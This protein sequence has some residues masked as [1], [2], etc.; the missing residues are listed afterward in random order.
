M[1]P[2]QL[3]LLP[4]EEF[5]AARD[6]AAK[7]AK[8][9]P[10]VARSL[11]AL[12]RPSVA[13]WLVNRLVAEQP[14]LVDQLLDLGPALAAAQ[15][16]G[17]GDELRALG[18]QRRA[19][20]DAV[21]ATAVELADRPVS[22]AVRDEV[23]STL[24]AGLSDPGAAGAVR[25]GRLVRALSYA[26]F[27]GVDL[28]GAVAVGGARPAAPQKKPTRKPA[29]EASRA[30]E[31]AERIAA[32]ETE[33]LHAAGRLDDAVRAC[34][35]AESERAAAE[36]HATAADAEVDRLRA[37]LEEA[38]AA[39]RAARSERKRAGEA[40]D[41]AVHQVRTRQAAEEKARAELD[42]LRREKD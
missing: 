38:E 40:A 21:V 35:T 9:D 20:V 7:A 36:E 42:R 2:E 37:A 39:A 17:D 34:E 19:L 10:D 28:D 6:A 23:A 15:A 25:S 41:R 1:G 32:A 26:G 31:R 29:K 13:A 3:Y 16:Q 27:G 5:T 11:K 14:G 4:P 12:R 8:A 18:G 30:A 33:A 22:A 24:E